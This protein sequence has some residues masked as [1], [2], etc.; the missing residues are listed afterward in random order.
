MT[1]TFRERPSRSQADRLEALRKWNSMRHHGAVDSVELSD[2]GMK[3]LIRVDPKIIERPH[4]L[5]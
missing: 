2:T 4:Y 5:R 1:R 3:A